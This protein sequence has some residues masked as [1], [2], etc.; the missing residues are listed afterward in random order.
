MQARLQPGGGRE[1]AQ[2]RALRDGRAAE[3]GGGGEA[4][5][6]HPPGRH[7]AGQMG[8]RVHPSQGAIGDAAEGDPAAAVCRKGMGGRDVLHR[9]EPEIIAAAELE[10]I[11]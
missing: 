6:D 8:P 7:G 3:R 2:G 4:A 11:R 10:V 9:F 1:A 5:G